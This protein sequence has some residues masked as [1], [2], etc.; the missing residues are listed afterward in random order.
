M[1]RFRDELGDWR[2]CLLTPFGARV[3]A[4]WALAIEARLRE[5]LG[6]DVQPIWSD[7]GIVVRLPMTDELAGDGLACEA[8]DAGPGGGRIAWP[9]RRRRSASA[10]EDVEELVIGALGGSALFSSHFRENAARA[11]LLPRRRAGQRTPLW[12]MRQRS[13]QLLGVASRYGSFPIILE[14]YRECLQDV[15]DLPALQGDPGRDR[16]ARDPPRERRDAPRV[17]LREL[18]ACSTTSPRT[19]TRATRRWSTAGRRRWRSTATCCA[20][21]SAPRSC[22]SCSMRD[23]L[24]ELELELQALTA[25]ARGGLGRRR[26]T[27]CC[28]GWAT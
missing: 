1:Q 23:A 7:D 26:C 27:T 12:Q 28:A 8:T 18:A 22:A 3:H 13:A 5:R 2:I 17:A 15:F 14:T 4:P 24:A 6:L 20:S 16:A 9:R 10:S 19:C 21:C 25:G 11:L